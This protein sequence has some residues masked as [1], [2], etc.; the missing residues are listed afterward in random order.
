[1]QHSQLLPQRRGQ[2]GGV[3]TFGSQFRQQLLGLFDR[4]HGVVELLG[5][6]ERGR[7]LQIRFDH[8]GFGRC[9]WVGAA[10]TTPTSTLAASMIANNLPP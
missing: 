9:C 5:L 10:T 1:M 7:L 6:G 2:L 3:F 4:F 8:L